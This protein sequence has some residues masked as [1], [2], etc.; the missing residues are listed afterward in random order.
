MQLKQET[1][2]IET[3]GRG[4]VDITARISSFLDKTSISQGLCH[5]FL[6]HTS[7]SL[8]FCENYDPLVKQDLEAFFSKLVPDGDTLFKHDAEGPDDMPAHIRT[9]LTQN[10]LQVPI[11]EGKLKLG[12][13]QGIFLWEHR[14]V[15]HSRHLTLTILGD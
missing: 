6:A 1:F 10:S 4:V 9:V 12:T 8:L 14:L 15:P 5:V 2:I 3:P 11:I 7:A 13:W